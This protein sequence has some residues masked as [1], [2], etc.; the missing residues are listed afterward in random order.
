MARML[1]YSDD[2]IAQQLWTSGGGAQIVTR[3]A[4]LIGLTGT[5]PP[6]V[7][8][9]WGDTLVT[10]DDLVAVYR[11][12]LALPAAQRDLVLD[13]LRAA[14]RQA[15]DGTDQF[16]GIPTAFRDQ[17]WA[18]KQAWA[19]GR[20][21]VDAHTSGLVGTGDRYVV[22]VLTHH[23]EGGALAAATNQLTSATQALAP[24]LD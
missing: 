19:E 11:Y 16:F 5:E 24:L 23:P 1:S 13:P 20:G 21:G 10:A 6:T 14:A 18:I 2:A 3:T 17:P 22:V 15:A 12:V 7:E 9:R 8:H 4:Q